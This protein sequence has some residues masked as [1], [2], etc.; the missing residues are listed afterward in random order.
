MPCTLGA[1]QPPASGSQRAWLTAGAHGSPS[2]RAGVGYP[3]P[4]LG[5]L[6]RTN[7]EAILGAKS[8][9]PAN[10]YTQGVAITSSFH[11]DEHTHIEPRGTARAATPWA[12]CRPR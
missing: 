8:P 5:T 12:C 10:D 2:G 11:P 9:T 7:S 6:T 1:Y 4:R 3:S